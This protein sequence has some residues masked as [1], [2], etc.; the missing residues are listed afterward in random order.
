MSAL[1]IGLVA[2]S[3]WLLIIVS[4]TL[5]F[6]VGSRGSMMRRRSKQRTHKHLYPGW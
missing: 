3:I 6:I 2:V 1:D 4:G 5:W